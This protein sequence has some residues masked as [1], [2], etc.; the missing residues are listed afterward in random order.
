MINVPKLR[1]MLYSY[2]FTSI[3]FIL[4]PRL[5]L[6]VRRTTAY[7]IGGS[8]LWQHQ[9]FKGEIIIGEVDTKRT[10][11]SWCCGLWGVR[12][13]RLTNR[14]KTNLLRTPLDQQDNSIAT[15][16]NVPT[17]G[18]CRKQRHEP[19]SLTHNSDG[20]CLDTRNHWI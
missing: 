11:V 14:M 2:N 20:I 16:S 5:V 6:N 17:I 8:I 18:S 10:F 3:Y 9:Y 4:T 13:L 12:G 19:G 7:A 1:C 15:R